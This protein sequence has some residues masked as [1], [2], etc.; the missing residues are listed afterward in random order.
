M[1]VCFGEDYPTHGGKTHKESR[2]SVYPVVAQFFWLLAFTSRL[3]SAC[4]DRHLTLPSSSLLSLCYAG[5]RPARRS[6]LAARRSRVR[7]DCA[8]ASLFSRK[9]PRTDLQ[10]PRTDLQAPRTDLQALQPLRCS[11][12]AEETLPKQQFADCR[13]NYWWLIAETARGASPSLIRKWSH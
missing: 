13:S 2:A 10:A 8:A 1:T 5:L 4:R 12:H 6:M 7:N 9:A 11:T 3:L